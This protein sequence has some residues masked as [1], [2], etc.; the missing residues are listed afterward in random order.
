MTKFIAFVQPGEA[1]KYDFMVLYQAGYVAQWCEDSQAFEPQECDIVVCD[2]DRDPVSAQEV[3]AKATGHPCSVIFISSRTSCDAGPQPHAFLPPGLS[4]CDFVAM[5]ERD[6]V[7][8]AAIDQG[9][10]T[11]RPA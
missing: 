2:Y 1:P 6:L 9:C 11:R 5:L 10:T 4:D 8:R 3:L 7:T